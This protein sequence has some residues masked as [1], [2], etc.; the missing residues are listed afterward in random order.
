YA[1]DRTGAEDLVDE[2][3]GPDASAPSGVVHIV[4]AG[5][6]DPDLLTVKALR[7]IQ[8][9]DIVYYDRLVSSDIMDLVRRDADRVC[10]GKEKGNHS[11]PQSEIHDLLVKAAEDGLRVVRLKGGDP[12][13]FG[14][15]GEELAALQAANV[16]AYVVPGISS[17]LGCAASAGLPLT[18]RD[19]A[20]TLTFVTGH[21]KSGQVPELDWPKLAAPNQTLVVF[22]GVGTAAQISQ[23]LI[24]AGR[25]GTTPVAVIENGTR[26]NEI[27]VFG[28]LEN[29]AGLITDAGI[30]GPAL[31][32][33]GEVAGLPL[34]ALSTLAMETAA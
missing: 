31:L 10:V 3:L 20:Q 34:E 25:P 2:M 4:G 32:I 6:G 5:P 16:E 23:H 29:L 7:L 12:F 27:R 11:V 15:G 33:I 18:H 1:G 21:A 13:I 30:K 14:R 19:H 22:M 9:A 26:D 8:Q 17:A 24:S 28:K